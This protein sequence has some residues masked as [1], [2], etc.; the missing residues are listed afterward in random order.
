MELS[1]IIYWLAQAGGGTVATFLLVR[2]AKKFPGIDGAVT[3]ATSTL[4]SGLIVWA[5]TAIFEGLLKIPTGTGLNW[6]GGFF[7]VL[8]PILATAWKEY[9]KHKPAAPPITPL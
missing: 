5:V 1:T 6:Q 8:S 3:V 2:F 7:T 9:Q 4:F